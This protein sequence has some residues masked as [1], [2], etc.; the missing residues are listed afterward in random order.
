[1]PKAVSYGV[2]LEAIWSPID[3]LQLLLSYAFND[4]HITKPDGGGRSRPTRP[5]CRPAPSR[6]ARSPPARAPGA[7]S[8]TNP[9]PNPLCDVFSHFVQRGQNLEGNQ[10]PQSARNKVAVNATYSWEFEQ[11][12]LSPSVS[13][14][15]RDKQ[16]GSIFERAYNESPSWSQV[17]ARV[18]WKGKENKYSVI[19]YVK[20]LFDDLGYDGGAVGS[21]L[22]GTSIGA[23]I[24]SP[25][26]N[27]VQPGFDVT[28]PLTPPRT[29]GVELQYR[30]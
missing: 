26:I 16:Y 19:A 18:T 7:A 29:Y 21:R 8:A 6:S 23:S 4:A 25:Q 2:E 27:A 14:I 22:A 5:A 12:S 9:T 1:M 17:D 11:G 15:W 13:Y 30:F 3:H 28:Y 20:N 10:L 24:A